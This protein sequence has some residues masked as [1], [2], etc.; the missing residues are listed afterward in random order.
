[1]ESPS[2]LVNW[3]LGPTTS[4][5]SVAFD[6]ESIS[7][8]PSFTGRKP[9]VTRPLVPFQPVF[10]VEQGSSMGELAVQ[11]IESVNASRSAPSTGPEAIASSL[12][13]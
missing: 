3:R 13:V 1:M 10:S 12:N 9:L 2:P 11:A 7:V 6:D 8:R 5:T 4:R